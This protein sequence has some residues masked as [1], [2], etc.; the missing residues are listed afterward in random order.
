MQPVHDMSPSCE[1]LFDS[2]IPKM[3]EAA[4]QK[5]DDVLRRMLKTPPKPHKP[6]GKRRKPLDKVAKKVRTRNAD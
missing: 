5:R 3:A 4:N 6:V 2:R 1:H